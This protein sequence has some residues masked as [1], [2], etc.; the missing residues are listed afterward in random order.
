MR[1]VGTV[2]LL[3]LASCLPASS[4]VRAGEVVVAVR[5]GG[6]LPPPNVHVPHVIK[7]GESFE[8]ALTYDGGRYL[9]IRVPGKSG[10]YRAR[11]RIFGIE[12]GATATGAPPRGVAEATSPID[13]FRGIP[14]GASRARVRA[15]EGASPAVDNR[16]HLAYDV[17]A[18]GLPAL[19]IFE[20]EGGELVG[21][22]YSFT[23]V[24]Y[25][26]GA[27]ISDFE[28]VETFLRAEYGPGTDR[29]RWFNDLFRSS[30]GDWGTALSLGQ[31]RF[32]RE[33][34]HGDRGVLHKL[35]RDADGDLTHI[36]LYLTPSVGS[37]DSSDF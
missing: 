27:L 31:V 18:G 36:V 25:D 11:P 20:F 15:S 16:R 12:V 6:A 34:R 35:E 9:N 30:R 23:A 10:V 37:G 19:A 5:D 4:Q 32:E 1:L 14:F 3:A 22:G 24:R 17:T 21:G 8:V 29:T 7:A 26:P 33:W 13:G 28:D 2:V